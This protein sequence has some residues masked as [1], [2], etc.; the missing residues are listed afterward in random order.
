MNHK[1]VHRIY[2]EE[3]L[4]L[5]IRR[6]KKLAV[7]PRVPLP[8]AT[9]TDE[10]WSMDFVYDQLAGGKRY[11]IF[12]LVDLHSRECLALHAGFSLRAENVVAI[13]SAL[14]TRNRKPRAITVD[15]GSE[16][17]S[18]ELELWAYTSGVLLDFIRPGKPVENGY[19]ESFNGKLRDECL[20]MQLFFSLRE[21]QASL[22]KWRKEYNTLRPH[23]SLGG[24][25]PREFAQRAKQLA[26][27]P[28]LLK[29]A[30]V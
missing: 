29:H 23:A 28:F 14:K 10:R 5:Q 30:L 3:R 20:N 1:K 26:P 18:K 15:N 22:A 11:R 7:V 9:R 4:Q 13:L 25:P 27:E 12:T 21:A 8:A 16:F 19:I 24:M 6:K 17:V 2:K